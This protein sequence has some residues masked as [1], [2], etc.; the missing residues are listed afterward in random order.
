[1]YVLNCCSTLLYYYIVVCSI[2]YVY[3]MHQTL[4]IPCK[5][6]LTLAINPILILF[7][8]FQIKEDIES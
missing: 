1:M 6:K 8:L 5:C 7:L 2:F 4:Q 3:C